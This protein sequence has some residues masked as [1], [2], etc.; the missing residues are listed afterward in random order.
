MAEIKG[1]IEM[2]KELKVPKLPSGEVDPDFLCTWC[3]EPFRLYMNDEGQKCVDAAEGKVN[4]V[5]HLMCA[6]CYKDQ[7][8]LEKAGWYIDIAGWFD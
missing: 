6:R 4:G 2:S 7:I 3:G 1:A 5:D 8:K